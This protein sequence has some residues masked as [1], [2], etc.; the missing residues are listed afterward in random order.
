[1]VCLDCGAG[2]Y[3]FDA[4]ARD[5]S[6]V[7]DD[8]LTNTINSDLNPLALLDQMAKDQLQ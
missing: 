6:I 1:M 8:Y 4:N 2:L 3:V 5:P 7:V